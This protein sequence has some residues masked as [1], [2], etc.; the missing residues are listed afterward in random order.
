ME[1]WCEE[2]GGGIRI[3]YVEIYPYI[4]P[5]KL[6]ESNKYWVAFKEALLDMDLK[7]RPE[8]MPG[9]TD[10][11]YL[12]ELNIPAIGFSPMNNTPVLLH[13]HDEYLQADVFLKGIEIYKSVISAVANI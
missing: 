5:T 12:R 4:E 8:I 7:V 11:R 3:E 10:I 6:D 2:S 13:D 1:K 9:A